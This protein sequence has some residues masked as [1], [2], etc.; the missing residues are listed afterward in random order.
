MDILAIILILTGFLY[1]VFSFIVRNI[2]IKKDD[3]S[4]SKRYFF[5]TDFKYINKFHYKKFCQFFDKKLMGWV[6]EGV[7]LLFRFA[8]PPEIAIATFFLCIFFIINLIYDF[9][10]LSLILVPPVV[11][12]LKKGTPFFSLRRKIIS[13]VKNNQATTLPLLRLT[14]NFPGRWSTFGQPFLNKLEPLHLQYVL[15]NDIEADTISNYS[16][17]WLK[18]NLSRHIFLLNPEANYCDQ[19]IDNYFA[20]AKDYTS[21]PQIS[22]LGLFLKKPTA[23]TKCKKFW[24]F[25]D[26]AGEVKVVE[27]EKLTAQPALA[28]VLIEL[29]PPALNTLKIVQKMGTEFHELHRTIAKGPTPV[30]EMY[31][32]ICQVDSLPQTVFLL[33]D[34]IDAMLRLTAFTL[35]ALS[36][37]SIRSLSNMEEPIVGIRS[38]ARFVKQQIVEN[39]LPEPWKR[40]FSHIHAHFPQ[41]L[42]A[43][44]LADLQTFLFPILVEPG[45]KLKFQ[46]LANLITIL[47]NKT[48]GHGVITKDIAKVISP[49]LFRISVIMAS[50]IRI[51]E[52][53]SEIVGSEYRVKIPASEPVLLSPFVWVSPE[54]NNLFFLLNFNKYKRKST[55]AYVDYISGDYIRP[56]IKEVIEEHL[57]SMNTGHN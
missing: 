20:L 27:S 55:M 41:D 23:G 43:N 3:N 29:R 6:W 11:Y 38:L 52:I 46:G 40:H 39:P 44:D 32:K 47:R 12:F 19:E 49:P 2:S 22:L 42:I 21:H 14:T 13:S 28:G 4:F 24:D 54:N 53:E 18:N 5:I 10:L 7:E 56:E 8:K 33:F 1:L 37:K 16:D 9:P 34:L 48:R 50:F 57:T 45:N 26:G 36:G 35:L 17:I 31:R 30:A 15:L 25:L 51:N